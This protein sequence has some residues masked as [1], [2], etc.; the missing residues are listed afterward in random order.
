[1]AAATVPAG[2]ADSA[3]LSRALV[4]SARLLSQWSG[5][6][7]QHSAGALN[8][9]LDARDHAEDAAGPLH[10]VTGFGG[11]GMT[12]APGLAEENVARWFG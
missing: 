7:L 2:G 8:L 4:S 6:Y 12:M 10:V 11:A 1:M 5:V 3:A 9:S